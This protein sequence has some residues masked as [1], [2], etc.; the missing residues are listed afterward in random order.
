MLIT[1]QAVSR[2]SRFLDGLIV[3][4]ALSICLLNEASSIFMTYRTFEL[5][6]FYVTSIMK[7]DSWGWPELGSFVLLIGFVSLE[8]HGA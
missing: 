3:V 1:A 6:L 5:G 2:L 4:K 8:C 7:E